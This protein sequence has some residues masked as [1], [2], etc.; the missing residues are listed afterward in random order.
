[1]VQWYY[2]YVYVEISVYIIKAQETENP[3]TSCISFQNR[4]TNVKVIEG[5]LEIASNAEV[6]QV[7]LNLNFRVKFPIDLYVIL[8]LQMKN[9]KCFSYMYVQNYFNQKYVVHS[10]LVVLNEF[11]L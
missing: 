3:G 1:M 8:Q 7:C 2:N 4:K 11:C 10:S 6:G 9:Q 5:L